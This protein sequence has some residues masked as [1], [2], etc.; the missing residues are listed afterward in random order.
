MFR[1]NSGYTLIEMTVVIILAGLFM[2][3]SIPRFKTDILTDSLKTSTRRIVALID[4]LRDD[5]LE[6]ESSY[7]LRFDKVSGRY[8][9]ESPDMSEADRSLAKE[10]AI[11]LPSDVSIK[12]IKTMGADNVK[13][14]E[15]SIWFHNK[16]YVQPAIIWLGSEDG[17]EMSV[18]LRPFLRKTDVI[19]GLV[20]PEDIRF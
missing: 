13:P 16:G 1:G 9:V 2:T 18:I 5:A 3:Y 6:K 14:G 4:S 8:W 7:T 11:S 19:E 20:E 12:D 15:P 10:N 17:R